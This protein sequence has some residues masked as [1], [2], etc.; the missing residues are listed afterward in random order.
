MRLMRR[1]REQAGFTLVELMITM[2]ILGIL[3]TIVVLTMTVSKNKA[4]EA[5]CKANLRTMFEAV[6]VYQSV[7]GTYPATLD[8]LVTDGLIKGSFGW[9]CPAGPL[10]GTS[11][12]YR[13]YYDPTTGH[14]SCPRSSHN[15]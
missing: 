1:A 15:P 8:D 4:Q 13:D 6:N 11:T 10:G 7:H 12:D 5:A 14:T 3:V 9:T 2:L